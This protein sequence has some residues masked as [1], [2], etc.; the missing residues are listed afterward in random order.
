MHLPDNEVSMHRYIHFLLAAS[1]LL[2]ISCSPEP[3]SSNAPDG[4]PSSGKPFK[5]ALLTPGSVSDAGWNALAY[6][7][8]LNIESELG[9]QIKHVETKS[10]QEFEP[11][12][13]NFG[14]EGYD[15]VIGHGFEYQDAAAAVC[16]DFPKTIY[17]TTSGNT[18]R[19]NVSPIVFCMEEATYL[20]G[21]VSARMSK[22]GKLGLLGGMDIPSIESSFDTFEQGAKSVR[23]D[24]TVARSFVGNW[25]DVVKANEATRALINQGVDFIFHNADAAGRG[26]FQ[27]IQNSPGAYCFGSNANQNDLAPNNTLASAV[28]RPD[29]FTMIAREVREGNFK[30]EIKIL[31]MKNGAIVIEWNEKLKDQIPPEV[32][33]EF[34][35]VQE[36]IIKG[37][38]NI[39]IKFL[40]EGT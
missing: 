37:E 23:S 3:E 4:T 31:D 1:L 36:K 34:E 24:V 6:R 25:E 29:A 21:I 30:P 19:P 39:P 2:A 22:T 33:S 35:S 28:I 10:V 18:V 32:L 13:R 14:S 15:L 40:Q 7:G 27:A 9:A 11:A 20:L 38:L 26:M 12:F 16:G 8:L 17:I 5:V